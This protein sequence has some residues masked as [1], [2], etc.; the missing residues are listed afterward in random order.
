MDLEQAL[1]KAPLFLAIIFSH[2]CLFLAELWNQDVIASSKTGILSN[3]SR[4]I[5]NSSSY[6][7]FELSRVKLYRKR[8]EGKC[9]L[10]RGSGR[11]EL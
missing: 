1:K 2:F 7:E 3:C 9:K 5:E 10:L 6:R 11:F 4:E 8:S